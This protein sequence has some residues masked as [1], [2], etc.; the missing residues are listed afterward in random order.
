MPQLSEKIALI[1]GASRGIGRGIALAFAREG[2]SL[3]LTARSRDQLQ[4]AA[5]EAVALSGAPTVIHPAD[6]SDERQVEELFAR[7]SR[8]FGRLN[9]LV[10]NAGALGG[11]PL[12][13]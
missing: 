1:T 5:N 8:E 6:V 12:A 13:E 10:N 9:I 11:G 4:S 2:A 3:L 7:V